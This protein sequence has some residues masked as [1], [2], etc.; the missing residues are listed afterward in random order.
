[1]G[2]FALDTA[3]C[4]YLGMKV[5]NQLARF[6]A[7]ASRNRTRDLLMLILTLYQLIYIELVVAS[8]WEKLIFIGVGE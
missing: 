3:F 8:H 5:F 7:A 4:P 1:V 6:D 2:V